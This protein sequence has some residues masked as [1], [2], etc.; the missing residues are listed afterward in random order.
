MI[1]WFKDLFVMLKRFITIYIRD[2]FRPYGENK[3]DYSFVLSYGIKLNVE[4]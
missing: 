3:D 2:E 1:S 4:L